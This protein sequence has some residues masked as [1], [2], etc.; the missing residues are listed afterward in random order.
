ML[1]AH[2]HPLADTR[3][4]ISDGIKDEL[5][6]LAEMEFASLSD[7][8]YPVLNY[9]LTSIYQASVYEALSKVISSL[10]PCQGA[11][12]RLLDVL[13]TVSTASRNQCGG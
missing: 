8:S 12:E 4:V 9:H 7:Y 2:T 11:L 10:M 3:Q 13:S 6:D 1:S 5:T